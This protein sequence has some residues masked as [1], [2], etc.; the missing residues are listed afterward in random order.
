VKVEKKERYFV[1]IVLPEPL[2][3]TVYKLKQSFWELYESKAALSSPPHI[4]LHMPFDWRSDKEEELSATLA[5]FFSGQSAQRIVL[6]NFG[7][8]APRVI[9]INVAMAETL[10]S[11][12]KAMHQFCKRELNLFN[13]DY[14]DHPFHPHVTLAF[15]DLKKPMFVKAWEEFKEKNFDAEFTT[16]HVTILKH[17]GKHWSSWKNLKLS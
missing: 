11:F 15:R 9:Y 8:F 1:G 5:E 3:A 6:R 2:L 10:T 13:A 16:D 17:N 14:Q 4:T 7:C 12:Q